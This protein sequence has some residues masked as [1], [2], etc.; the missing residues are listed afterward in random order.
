MTQRANPLLDVNWGKS[1]ME[2][3]AEAKQVQ[4][5]EERK[6]QLVQL[7][8]EYQDKEKIR[9]QLDEA[10]RLKDVVVQKVL[11]NAVL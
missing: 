6:A 11:D 8:K 10:K 9:Q 1:K 5:E 3:I 7:L 4:A 2:I